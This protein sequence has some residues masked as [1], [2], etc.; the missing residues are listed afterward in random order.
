MIIATNT[1]TPP[2]RCNAN[3]TGQLN[4]AEGRSCFELGLCQAKSP[5][6][7]GC[8]WKLAPGVI[9]GPYRRYSR[10][11]A[12]R[13]FQMRPIFFWL[14]YLALMVAG[15]AYAAGRYGWL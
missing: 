2:T 8:D 7:S 5:A 13:F 6:C 9:D 15:L 11:L 12:V 3:P 14:P 4:T 1:N 10:R